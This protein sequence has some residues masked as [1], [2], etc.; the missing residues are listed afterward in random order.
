M[1]TTEKQEK[2]VPDLVVDTSADCVPTTCADKN[3]AGQARGSTDVSPNA[4]PDRNSEE[5]PNAKSESAVV[6]EGAAVAAP[7]GADAQL[8]KNNT[9]THTQAALGK[10]QSQRSWSK[11]LLVC[12]IVAL[13]LFGFAKLKERLDDEQAFRAAMDRA[14]LQIWRAERED[15]SSR[16]DDQLRELKKKSQTD[17]RSAFPSLKN[18]IL[19]A[20]KM[21]DTPKQRAALYAR[22]A[23]VAQKG[24]MDSDLSNGLYW[25]AFNLYGQSPYCRMQQIEVLRHLSENLDPLRPMDPSSLHKVDASTLHLLETDLD[26][27][28]VGPAIDVGM[29]YVEAEHGLYRLQD[30]LTNLAAM[31]E[32]DSKEDRHA[33]PFLHAVVLLSHNYGTYGI[34]NR[35]LD[36]VITRMGLNANSAQERL[37]L[38]DDAFAHKDWIGAIVEYE[39][40]LALRHDEAVRKKLL[41]SLQRF[42]RAKY[43]SGLDKAI[44]ARE[45]R[46]KL[47]S[48]LFGANGNQATSERSRLARLYEHNGQLESAESLMLMVS[49]GPGYFWD[50]EELVNIY[51][52]EGKFQEA[53]TLCQR[54]SML[55]Q[56]YDNHHVTDYVDSWGVNSGKFDRMVTKTLTSK[57]TSLAQYS[58]EPL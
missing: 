58:R 24:G 8:A 35:S 40:S 1:D 36:A 5:I 41:L 29:K 6:A 21:N 31:L 26:K 55:R 46:L 45:Q 28:A 39:H 16:Y 17:Y 44:F 12:L 27:K 11:V 52:E 56:W 3:A 51:I 48:E 23:E 25:N 34:G 42:A 53:R 43:P 37:T 54:S 14:E 2:S 49:K 10:G 19:L 33:L 32:S 38:A 7:E 57:N 20:Q 50:W 30:Q 13:A 4:N 15:L 9:V 22:V 47:I 18:A